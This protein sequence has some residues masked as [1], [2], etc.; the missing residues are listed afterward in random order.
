MPPE[1]E[2]VINQ[3]K[4]AVKLSFLFLFQIIEGEAPLAQAP[5]SPPPLQGGLDHNLLLDSPTQAELKLRMVVRAGAK[6]VGRGKFQW[7]RAGVQHLLKA[8]PPPDSVCLSATAGLWLFS[9]DDEPD[10]MAAVS[11]CLLGKP[12]PP[13]PPAHVSWI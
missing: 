1:Q 4:Q 6:P 3:S 2:G 9:D 5:S 13:P 12:P 7:K 10:N 8:H 11:T